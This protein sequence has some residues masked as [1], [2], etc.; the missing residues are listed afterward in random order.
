MTVTNSSERTHWTF[1]AQA[2]RLGLVTIFGVLAILLFALPFSGEPSQ[3]DV[4][5]FVPTSDDI[6]IEEYEYG[7]GYGYEYPTPTPAPVPS[8]TEW[9]LIGLAMLLAAFTALHLRAK[10]KPEVRREVLRRPD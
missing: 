7:Y 3:F 10:G 4:A 5:S 9:G 2:V 1:R 6:G 8:A